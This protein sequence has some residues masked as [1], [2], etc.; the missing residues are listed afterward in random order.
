MLDLVV[1][2]VRRGFV[3]SLL[4]LCFAACVSVPDIELGSEEPPV[5]V[6]QPVCGAVKVP[7]PAPVPSPP[8]VTIEIVTSDPNQPLVATTVED[9]EATA[10]WLGH[11]G[12]WV[13]Q[14]VAWIESAQ[15][16][17]E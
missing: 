3:A 16:C 7:A 14:A 17:A 2:I 12:G 13:D 1:F 4:L 11:L 15:S 5:V 9:Y 10:I 8:L 6:S